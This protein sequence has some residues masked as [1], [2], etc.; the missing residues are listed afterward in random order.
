MKRPDRRRIVLGGLA[1][2]GAW[3]GPSRAQDCSQATVDR[4]LRD[5][6]TTLRDIAGTLDY[7]EG[8]RGRAKAKAVELVEPATKCVKGGYDL[9]RAAFLDCNPSSG[10]MNPASCI[11]TVAGIPDLIEDCRTAHGL[12]IEIL[13]L[14]RQARDV[15]GAA[16]VAFYEQGADAYADALSA[17]GYP[18]CARIAGELSQTARLRRERTERD[19][20]RMTRFRD[21]LQSVEAALRA[22]DADTTQ[23]E[24]IPLYEVPTLEDG[25]LPPPDLVLD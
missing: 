23:C 11:E 9:L 25:E 3:A 17:C 7:A 10:A 19:M 4:L 5:C 6:E 18:A 8:L 16:E 21:Q 14:L 13:D 20:A 15:E 2:A 24:E 1:A 12:V 22:C